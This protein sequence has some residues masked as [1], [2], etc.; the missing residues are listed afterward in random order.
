[1]RSQFRYLNCTKN[2]ICTEKKQWPTAT[3]KRRKQNAK[4]EET[5]TEKGRKKEGR[6]SKRWY[7]VLMLL[8]FGRNPYIF[9]ALLFFN[10]CSVLFRFGTNL[11]S[12]FGLHPFSVVVCARKKQ[13]LAFPMR[14]VFCS[15]SIN[16]FPKKMNIIFVYI[17]P[18]VLVS[19]ITTK[20]L[21][22]GTFNLK[23]SRT[24]LFFNTYAF[25]FNK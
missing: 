18:N 12:A 20:Q 10:I 16:K 3:P 17:R 21:W 4:T 2:L 23:Y 6:E 22:K 19:T 24:A 1:M 13:I 14:R 11:F 8:K 5:R 9:S 7:S 15:M 25:C